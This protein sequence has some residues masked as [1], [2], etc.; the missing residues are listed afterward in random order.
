MITLEYHKNVF[1]MELEQPALPSRL[2]LRRAQDGRWASGLKGFLYGWVLRVFQQQTSKGGQKCVAEELPL[3]YY[4]HVSSIFLY[5]DCASIN[6]VLRSARSDISLKILASG[7]TLAFPT[8]ASRAWDKVAR[9]RT[10]T[11]KV[12]R[13]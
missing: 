5:S 13:Q 7:A 10:A 3:P 6:K 4:P 1:H 8:L 11:N 2:H 12:L 9:A